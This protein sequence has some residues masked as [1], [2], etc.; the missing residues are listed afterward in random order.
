MKHLNVMHGQL[1]AGTYVA[2][3]GAAGVALESIAMEG[4]GD[5]LKN[6]WK[7]LKE[8][9]SPSDETKAK[10]QIEV[11]EKLLK[12]TA[13]L[14]S[15]VSQT[16]DVKSAAVALSKIANNLPVSA[17]SADELVR[18]LAEWR[19]KTAAEL[20]RISKIKD[21]AEA[22]AAL[23]KIKEES[24]KGGKIIMKLT[25]TKDNLLKLLDEISN[26]IKLCIQ[27]CKMSLAN[28]VEAANTKPSMESLNLALESM[29][30]SVAMEGFWTT[31]L[32]YYMLYG[33]YGS[34]LAAVLYAICAIVVLCTG[35]LGIA[36][37]Y[38]AGAGVSWWLGNIYKSWADQLLGKSEDDS[39]Y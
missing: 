34:Y 32:G 20:S 23:A 10:A 38:A 17:N 8:K 18:N 12:D 16:N 36:A 2:P 21:K 13:E 1:R 4:I 31:V 26:V 37:I 9:F 27:T 5:S 14:K 22:D 3:V 24:K 6:G 15:H 19:K 30:L 25:F 28:K 29:D 35:S 33:A 39:E 11:M 7:L